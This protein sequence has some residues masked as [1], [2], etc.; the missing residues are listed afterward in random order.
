MVR[1]RA[2]NGARDEAMEYRKVC[3]SWIKWT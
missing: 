3:G 1:C 2:G